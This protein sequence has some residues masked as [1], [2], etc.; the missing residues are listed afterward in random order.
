MKEK[1]KSFHKYILCFLAGILVVGSISVYA[2]TAII[3]SKEVSY[4]KKNS[5]GSY[6]NVQDSIDEL[7]KRY[8]D[9]S[10]E[11][12]TIYTEKILNGADPV[13]GDGMIPITLEDDG[14]VKYANLY[15]SWYKYAAKRWANA[16]ILVD[17][18]S[19]SYKIGDTILEKDIESYFVWVPRYKYKIWNLAKEDGYQSTFSNTANDINSIRYINGN[20]RIIDV[21]FEDNTVTPS[22]TQLVGSYYTHPAFTN[23]GVSGLWF[24]KFEV[25]GAVNAI[26]VKPNQV[27]LRNEKVGTFWKAFYNYRNINENHNTDLDPH[28]VKNTEWGAVAYLSHS[29]YGIGTQ[30]NI[31]NNS[32]FLTGYSAS[33][34]TDQNSYPGEYSAKDTDTKPYNT[35]IGYLASTTGNVTGIYDM[36]GG[37]Y[38]YVAGCRNGQDASTSGISDSMLNTYT[39]YFDIYEETPDAYNYSKRILGDATGEMGPFYFYKD[40]DIHNSWYADRSDFVTSVSS[41]FLR[42]GH[43]NYGALAS[44]YFF[45]VG[46][47]DANEYGSS[48]LVLAVK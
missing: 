8:K 36:S 28:M 32:K 39:N 21:I 14:T 26:A 47:G 38:E 42:G 41:W 23:F 18:P 33:P 1:K 6:D 34:T 7:Y 20:A 2:V 31:N 9:L 13:L 16:V 44:Q 46:N 24:S 15:T 30:I 4:D 48:R 12:D 40:S 35:S 29:A 25:S 19:Q 3:D 45:G 11:Q 5:N 43:Y 27:S 37:A 22:I 10:G 17:N